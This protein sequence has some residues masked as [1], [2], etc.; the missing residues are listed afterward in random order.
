MNIFDSKLG[1]KPELYTRAGKTNYE[2]D[3]MSSYGSYNHYGMERFNSSRMYLLINK[4]DRKFAA[5]DGK[6]K[7]ATLALPKGAAKAAISCTLLPLALIVD[8][9]VSVINTCAGNQNSAA[10]KVRKCIFLPVKLIGLSALL[11]VGLVALPIVSVVYAAKALRL[12]N[13]EYKANL[14]N[15]LEE[16][17]ND[18]QYEYHKELGFKLVRT[19]PR[20]Q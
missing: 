20:V 9:F 1:L 17:L 10:R 19:E 12:L 14:I 11:A 8:R 2:M 16:E 3:H 15:H 4:L 6:A 7:T 18:Y 13:S 5:L